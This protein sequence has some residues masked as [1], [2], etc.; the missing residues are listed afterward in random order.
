MIEA[1]LWGL[2]GASSLLI[3]AILAFVANLPRSIRGLIL[4][5]G[6]GA[7]FGAVAYELIADAVAPESAGLEV[8]VGF[9][10]G[11][12]VFYAGSGAIDHVA[13][14]AADGEDGEQ[15]RARRRGLSLLLG[16]VLDGIPE[17]V[18][19]GISLLGGGVGVPIL[20]AIFM[21]NLPE[22]FTASE[23]LAEA[24]LRRRWI[25]GLWAAVVVAS[26]IAAGLGFGLLQDAPSQVIGAIQAFAAGGILAMLAESAIPEAYELG[27]RPVSLATCLG[28]AVATYLSLV[29]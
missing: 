17:S 9:G 15:G 23:D 5:F 27:G 3:G 20:V 11:A 18:V 28:F 2:V 12:I 26:A 1:A 16:A 21:S 10:L 24:G 25:I 19:L 8:A 13:G 14:R 22:A 29:A 4:A 6:A 7:L